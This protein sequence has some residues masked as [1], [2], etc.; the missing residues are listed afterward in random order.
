MGAQRSKPNVTCNETTRA[1][2]EKGD[3]ACEPNRVPRV[4]CALTTKDAQG[5]RVRRGLRVFRGLK[6]PRVLR[7]LR[8]PRVL[9][10]L[11]VLRVGRACAPCSRSR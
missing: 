2:A 5:T 4:L 8:A 10:V 7:V 3:R 6:A 9:S 11:R 1:A